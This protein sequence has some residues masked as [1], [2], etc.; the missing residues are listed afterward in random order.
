MTKQDKIL[1]SDILQKKDLEAS[2]PKYS[3]FMMNSEYEYSIIK[4]ALNYYTMKEIID[5]EEVDGFIVDNMKVINNIL[6]KNIIDKEF[7]GDEY[8]KNITKINSIRNDIITKMKV[9]TAY[10]DTLQIY[11]HV[12]NRIEYGITKE[13]KEV[14]I[15]VL[16]NEVLQYLFC[17][18][19]NVVIN[20]KIQLV[21]GQLPVRMTKSRFYDEI[22]TAL[23]IYNGSDVEALNDFVSVIRTTAM[24]EIPTGYDTEYPE[25]YSFICELKNLD[26][27]NIDKEEFN[28]LVSKLA[29]E[30][31]RITNIVTNYL[32]LVEIINDVY[33]IL[34][35]IP[36][37]TNNTEGASIGEAI[38]KGV[39]NAFNNN[40]SV[41]ED[42]DELLVKL[43]G[44]QEAL[45]EDIM[46]FEGILF[47]IRMEHE[48]VIKAIMLEKVF[49]SLYIMEKLL[50]SSLFIELSENK[51]ENHVVDNSLI[52]C[53][54][55]ELVA[56]FTTLFKANSKL[57]NRSIM[58]TV[59]SCLP[60]FFN[61][62]QEIMDY[63]YYSLSHCNNDSELMAVSE[64]LKDIMQE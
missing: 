55:D 25:I 27:D 21:L 3:N 60:I 17:E 63:I 64:L 22:G 26:Y 43:E 7:S 10:T 56:D 57:V 23:A 59:I 48:D 62:Q 38:I 37:Y 12:L 6:E 19:D 14:D 50:S 45:Y 2:L 13:I 42:M 4:L 16:S 51:N 44:C 18:N 5:E 29:I 32:Q 36:Y 8:E 49:E 53:A 11:E 61:N 34:L 31:E 58:A 15:Q 30:A 47:D 46:V 41:S 52:M 20:S 40:S 33:I 1:L 9:L 54:R 39:N 28:R 35:A 24:L